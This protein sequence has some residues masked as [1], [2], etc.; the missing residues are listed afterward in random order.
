[1][2]GPALPCTQRG[3]PAPSGVLGTQAVRGGPPRRPGR[4]AV[5]QGSAGRVRGGPRDGRDGAG[6]A[7]GAAGSARAASVP[8]PA[9]GSK[10][11]A[12]GNPAG[13]PGRARQAAAHRRAGP[14][15]VIDEHDA[16]RDVFGGPRVHL[17]AAPGDPRRGGG[18]GIAGRRAVS[19]QDVPGGSG[20][21]SWEPLTA[22]TVAVFRPAGDV[23][24]SVRG[25]LRA[26]PP[27]V[28]GDRSGRPRRPS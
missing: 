2:T 17:P 13:G 26:R 19:A 12:G 4:G 3:R 10:A 5:R 24:D 25:A 15:P 6:A 14:D 21:G 28:R 7:A 27:P 8:D 11:A 22:P 1:M 20:A 9:P 18:R 23:R 16:R